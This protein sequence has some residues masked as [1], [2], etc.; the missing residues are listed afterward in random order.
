ME[1]PKTSRPQAAGFVMLEENVLALEEYRKKRRFD[2]TP[3]PRGKRIPSNK[4]RRPIFV[5]QKHAASHLHYDFRLEIGGVLVSWA[6]PK[7]PSMRTADRRLAMQTE[8]H[9]IDYAEFEGTI[10]EGHYGAGTVMVWDAGTFEFEEDADGLEQ[11]KRGTLKFRLVGEKLNGA[12]VLVHA[13]GRRWI[14]IKRR[15]EFAKTSW[16]IGRD[17]RSALSGRTMRQIAEG[18]G[19]TTAMGK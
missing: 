2:R 15:D 1:G 5:V 4:R 8:D 10:P 3:E 11:L 6:V 14:L 13:V 9:P 7:G 18:M 12:F 17:D 19:V 16:S